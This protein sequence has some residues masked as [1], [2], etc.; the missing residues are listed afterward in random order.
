MYF[1]ATLLVIAFSVQGSAVRLDNGLQEQGMASPPSADVTTE[2][3]PSS[4]GASAPSAS[5]APDAA[6]PVGERMAFLGSLIDKAK[7]DK[8]FSFVGKYNDMMDYLKGSKWI[9]GSSSTGAN[10]SSST[11]A[12]GSSSASGSSADS[13]GVNESSSGATGAANKEKQVREV[14]TNF[15]E[16]VKQ[17]ISNGFGVG[18]IAGALAGISGA[19]KE[20]VKG[21]EHG[22][23]DIVNNMKGQPVA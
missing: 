6:A 12:N 14:L 22:V 3:A 4:G 16:D 10:G 9:A 8:D 19:S 2:N 15:T 5:A 23:K 1:C 17:K 7:I 18:D 13:A 20:S 21:L 11:G